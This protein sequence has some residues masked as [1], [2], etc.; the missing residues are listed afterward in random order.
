MQICEEG[1]LLCKVQSDNI[2]HKTILLR[3]IITL[4]AQ[5]MEVHL[6]LNNIILYLLTIKHY[7]IKFI[8]AFGRKGI[9][10]KNSLT[11]SY[12]VFNYLSIFYSLSTTTLL[13]SLLLLYQS[14]FL[15][16]SKRDSVLRSDR[17]IHWSRPIRAPN[18]VSFRSC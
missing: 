2:V 6:L 3:I 8:R 16:K 12:S 13:D 9:I 4:R 15:T 14:V 5:V 18:A 10:S 17:L 1:I 11:R 7:I